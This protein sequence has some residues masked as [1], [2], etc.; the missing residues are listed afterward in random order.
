MKTILKFLS[1]GLVFSVILSAC[2]TSP[3]KILLSKNGKWNYTYKYTEIA[4]G[5]VTSTETGTLTFFD[6]DSVE[7]YESGSSEYMEY[8]KYH[9]SDN[10]LRFGVDDFEVTKSKSKEEIWTRTCSS[11]CSTPY[12]EEYTLTR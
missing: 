7:V 4:S 8:W 9:E 12:T 11:G 2:S 5:T 6:N 3:D 10:L 1:L